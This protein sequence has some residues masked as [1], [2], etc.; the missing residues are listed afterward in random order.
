[1]A[2]VTPSA[3]LRLAAALPL[4]FSLA[5]L[6]KP[7]A[8]SAQEV[9]DDY[10]PGCSQQVCRPQSASSSLGG[11]WI[12]AEYL[13]WRLDGA[14][15]LPP[16]LTDGPATEPLDEV[17]QLDNPTTRIL[18]GDET[19]GE[20]WRGGYR[21]YGGVWLDCCQ[22][23]GINADYF[24]TCGGDDN[25]I[26]GSSAD[27]IVTRPFFN[28]ETGEEDTQL[29]DVPNELE[30]TVEIN[31]SDDFSGAGVAL[32]RRLW[33]CCDPCG[34]GPS[35]QVYM[36]G[37]YRHYRYDSDL[38]ITENLLVLPGT[39]TPLVPGTTIFVEDRFSTENE[40]HGGELGFQGMVQRSCWWLD[41]LFKVAVGSHRRVVT[42]DGQTI[43]TVPNAGTAE[44]EGGFLTSEVTNIG[45]YA[46]NT[47]AVI[48]EF[49][50]GVG[51]Q[52]TNNLSVRAGYNLILWNAV[53]RAGSQLPP[54]LEVDPRNLPPVQPGGGSEPEFAGILGSTLIAHGFDVGVQFTY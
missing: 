39:T 52:L 17:G 1:M 23:W 15:D 35:S 42:I 22:C 18:F 32:Q 51:S 44:F 19:V 40:F 7:N 28:A 24:D 12:G 4:L 37:G 13:R 6:G 46:D 11:G 14:N 10:A 29:V 38:I 26:S 45:R 41:G 30:G 33:Q 36:L 43:N 31:S 16:L 27:R 53:A 48:P 34:C 9:Y 47:I 21:I 3:R 25:F 50:L 5:V 8:A 49:R 54:G 2:L 20:D